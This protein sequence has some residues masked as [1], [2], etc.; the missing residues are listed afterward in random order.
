MESNTI[1]KGVDDVKKFI[2]GLLVGFLIAFAASASA[3]TV[4]L[5][6]K[7]VQG[8]TPISLNGEEL[9]VKGAIIDGVTQAP[10]RALAEKLGLGVNYDP[11]Y[12]VILTGSVK[13]ATDL[14]QTSTGDNIKAEPKVDPEY[15]LKWIDNEIKT[16]EIIKFAHQANI[17]NKTTPESEKE[18]SRQKLKELDDRIAE[19]LAEKA[20]L[21]AQLATTPE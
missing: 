21:E 5:V 7:T 4:S 11:T 6:G 19:L 14:P 18:K 13:E 12:G 16:I 8:E 20:E 17:E 3:E 9:D 2:S 10:V 1:I 15:R